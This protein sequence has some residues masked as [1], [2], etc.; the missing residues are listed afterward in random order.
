MRTKQ[1]IRYLAFLVLIVISCAGPAMP[2][3]QNSNPGFKTPE[4]AITYYFEGLT[5]S[6]IDKIL[7]ACAINEMA[8]KYRFDLYTERVGGFEPVQSL[9]PTSHPFYVENNKLL[10]SS[11]ISNRVKMFAFSLLSPEM[12]NP[13]NGFSLLDSEQAARFVQ[14]VNPQRLASLELQKTGLP[15]KT[16]MSSANYLENAS[17]LAKIYGADESTER[18]AL[19]LFENNYFYL[20]FT[21]LRYGEN[22]KISSQTSPLA[23]ISSLGEP[24]QTTVEEFEEMINRE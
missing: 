7:G 18:V 14:E 13:A 19:F 11:Q 3:I 21:L 20:G 5:Q 15:D 12:G 6:D 17:E 9:S 23:D 1:M 4:E 10:L 2:A 24:E 16:V 8:E 22:W